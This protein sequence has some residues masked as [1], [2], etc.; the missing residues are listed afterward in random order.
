VE[1]I[2]IP[3]APDNHDQDFSGLDDSDQPRL[4]VI[5][6]QLP[7]ERRKQEKGKNEQALRDGTELSLTRRIRVELIR[8]EED[9]TL[10]E[11]T[12]VECAEK[13]GCEQG[14]E[15]ARTKQMSDVLH[16]GGGTLAEFG[17]C[18]ASFA[19]ATK[20]YNEQRRC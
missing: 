10:L 5:V 19:R 3:S 16:Q 12:V 2:P 17:G 14:R 9:D 13:L 7:C 8:H 11:Q 15:P 1:W 6:G 4:V 18:I 20:L